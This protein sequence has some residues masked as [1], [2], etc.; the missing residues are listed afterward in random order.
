MYDVY[1]RVAQCC[2]DTACVGMWESKFDLGELA[3]GDSPC[4]LERR[5]DAI[6][7]SPGQAAGEY[8]NEAVRSGGCWGVARVFP[9]RAIPYDENAAVSGL[10]GIV[11]THKLPKY[12]QT[13]TT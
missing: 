11:D 5:A 9:H 10:L 2:F 6:A 8:G 3:A 4:F 7:I 12:H 1:S 13:G